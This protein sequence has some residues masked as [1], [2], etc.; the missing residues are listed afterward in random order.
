M[1]SPSITTRLA[2]TIILVLLGGGIVVILAALA[3]GRQASDEAYDKLLAGAAFEISRAIAVADGKPYVDLPVAA[4]EILALA[5]DDRVFYRVMAED[6]TTLTGYAALPAPTGTGR[7]VE[8]YDG[9]IFATPVRLA[10][11]IRRMAEPGFSGG[12][13]VIVAQTTEARSALAWTIARNALVLLLVSG[14]M[15]VVLAM[16]AVASSLQP[17]RRIERILRRRDPVDLTPLEVAAPKEVE[18]MIGAINHFMSR[19]ARRVDAMQ[20][21]LA[22]STHQLRT[23]IAALRA[24][25][26]LASDETDP[27]QMRQIVDRIHQRTRGLSRLADQLLSRALVIHRADAIART[28]LDLRTIAIS[29]SE[30]IDHDL[31]DAAMHL[32]LDLPQE[33]VRIAGDSLSLVEA[34]KNLVTNAIKYGAA[35]VTLRVRGTPEPTLQVI[36]HGPGIPEET[37]DELGRRFTRGNHSETDGA[38]LGLAIVRSVA[39]AHGGTLGCSRPQPGTFAVTLS[40]P[41]LDGGAR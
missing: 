4:F 24:Q 27:A 22:D 20:N 23:P 29:A 38:G 37:W 34:T 7:T 12:V 32:R 35:P 39:D 41:P 5:P 6:G 31:S 25:A 30:E 36:D 21:M 13:R 33:E 10:S 18:A 1:F 2:A 8:F 26:Q 40:L 11:V 19:L 16:V 17:L 28:P 9:E 15:L 14:C 3:Y